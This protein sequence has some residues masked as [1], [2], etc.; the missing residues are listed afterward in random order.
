MCLIESEITKLHVKHTK[1]DFDKAISMLEEGY[2][3][4]KILCRD[5]EM[6]EIYNFVK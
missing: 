2:L 6:M 1:D 5:N 4:E 3:P